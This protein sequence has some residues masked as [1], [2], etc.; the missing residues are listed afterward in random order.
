M[1]WIGTRSARE[2]GRI[3]RLLACYQ[4][5]FSC[6]SLLALSDEC[7]LLYAKGFERDLPL[8]DIRSVVG[9]YSEEVRKLQAA[10]LW[11]DW[12]ELER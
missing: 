5:R 11:M 1:R 8:R 12:R 3:C 10:C 2:M 9:W 7:L 6:I 4:M